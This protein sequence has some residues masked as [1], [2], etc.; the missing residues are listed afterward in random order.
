VNAVRA[1]LRALLYRIR[2]AEPYDNDAAGCTCPRCDTSTPV[3]GQVGC[4]IAHDGSPVVQ[5]AEPWTGGPIGT[6]YTGTGRLS[7]GWLTY[8]EAEADW[9]ALEYLATGKRTEVTS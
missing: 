8:A 9:H 7:D 1:W 6:V 4:D 3:D 2:D 5:R